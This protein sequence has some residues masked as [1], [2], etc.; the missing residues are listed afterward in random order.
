MLGQTISHYKILEKLGEGGMGVVYKAHDTKLDRFV[1]LKFL[2]THLASSEQDK[3]RFIQEAKSAAALN[4]PNVC[5]IIDIQEYEEQMFIVMEFVDGQT[6]HEKKSSLTQKQAIDYGI[7]IADGLAA[8][9][10]KG[11]VHRDIKPENIMIRKDGIAQIMDFGLAKLRANGSEI[12]RLTKAGSTVG[13]I[14]YMSPEQVQGFDADHRS[15]I[16]SLGVLLYEMLTGQLPFKG[17]HETALMYEIVNVDTMPMSAVKPEIDTSLDAIILDCL[18]KDPKERCQSVAEIARDLRRIKRESSRSQVSRMTTLRTPYLPNETNVSSSAVQSM[19]VRFIDRMKNAVVFWIICAFLFLGTTVTLLLFPNLLS[20]SKNVDVIRAFIPEPEKFNYSKFVGGGQIAIS[21]DGHTITFVAVDSSGKSSLWIRPMNALN[22]TMFSGTEGAAT[23]FWSPDNRYIGFFADG[24]LKKIEADGGPPFSICDVVTARGASWNQYGIIVLPLDQLGGISQ[25][26]DAGGTP[27]IITTLDST[28]NEQTH[29]YPFFLPDGKNFLYLARTT[30][31]GSGSA[32]DAICIASVD[33]KLNKRILPG[34]S[35]A[36]FAAGHL[37]YMREN[38]LMAHAF[39]PDAL[40]L[41]GDAFP[42]VESVEFSTRFS[43]ATFSVSQTGIL[44]YQGKSQS[45][46]PELVLV[47][48]SGKILNS[49][50]Q[51]EIFVNAKLSNDCKNI[52]MDLYEVSARN[53]DLWLLDIE[54]N[55]RTRFT[56][57]AAVDFNPV[58]SPDGSRVFFS[59]NRKGKQNIYEKISNGAANEQLLIESGLNKFV[60]D[61]SPDGKFT[62]FN[63]D[64]LKNETDIWVLPFSGERK[65]TPLIA[66]EFDESNATFSRDMKWIAYQSNESGKNEVYVRPF[67]VADA[68][69]QVSTNGGGAPRWNDN[70]KE[71]FYG[72]NGKIM[73]AE[74]NGSGSTFV[75]GKVREHFDPAVLGNEVV[76]NNTLLDI[77]GDGQKI[78]MSILRGRQSS[79]PLTI[80]TNWTEDLR[81]K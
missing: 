18:E 44:V 47:N 9:H 57:D 45:S 13:T 36:T 71:I 22:A 64:D 32:L 33:G 81:K 77:S 67:P 7:Q 79:A 26:S 56:F 14:G 34:V 70:G 62:L 11:I 20:Y 6:L 38:T 78:L 30:A 54:R 69:W 42:I 12:T 17:V 43:V 39:D 72:S 68:K 4:H 61:I 1:A 8:A 21:P 58:W 28:R 48:P 23:P 51:P 52:V 75:V 66:T 65:P 24:K 35:N 40:E 80:V 15:D 19:E 73:L 49:F 41:K 3:A 16:F 31:S 5:S 25:V 63:S 74:V 29:R 60:T 27:T 50:G 53:A 55:V 76:G 59:S 2:S 10:E 46:T 37:L